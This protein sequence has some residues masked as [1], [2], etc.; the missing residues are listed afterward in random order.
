MCVS[1]D[2]CQEL[3]P[4]ICR[5]HVGC[6]RARHSVVIPSGL[7]SFR[8]R[9]KLVRCWLPRMAAARASQ[10]PEVSPHASNLQGQHAKKCLPSSVTDPST[11]WTSRTMFKM[12]V[13][14]GSTPGV[15]GPTVLGEEP[16]HFHFRRFPGNDAT[17]HGCWF[18]C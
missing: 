14:V 17:Y 15:S 10:Q 8:I 11:H 6:A 5:L 18:S 2:N 3:T 13:V 16:G 9:F 1:E 12:G 4:I 7:R